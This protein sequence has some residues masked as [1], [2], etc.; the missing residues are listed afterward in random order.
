MKYKTATGASLFKLVPKN[1]DYNSALNEKHN[2]YSQLFNKNGFRIQETGFPFTDIGTGM[3]E[4]YPEVSIVA[5]HALRN[6]LYHRDVERNWETVNGQD[7]RL[8]FAV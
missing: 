1:S 3:E 2:R 4:V 8:V 7:N 5:L 6:V